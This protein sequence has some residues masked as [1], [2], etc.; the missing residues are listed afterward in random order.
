M[1]SHVVV[2]GPGARRATVKVS[3]GTY[4]SDVL[5]QACK[6]L[7]LPSDKYVAKH[8]AKQVDLSVPFRTSGLSPGAKLDL[9]LKSNTPS[10]I[11]VA[12]QLPQPE[13]KDIP[14]G[15]L[16]RKFPSDLTLWQLLRQFESGDA[17]AGRNINITARGVAQMSN[18]TA[19]AGSGQLYYE[20]PVL[21]I[22]GRELSTLDDFQKT[23]SQ[24]GYNSGSV[25]IRL[26]YKVTD[27]TLYDTLER[28]GQYF[29]DV[30]DTLPKPASATAA[31]NTPVVEAP[32]HVQT[33]DSPMP[34]V[35]PTS[36]EPE[37]TAPATTP[38]PSNEA[39]SVDMPA[40]ASKDPFQPSHVYLAPSSDVPAAAKAPVREVDYTPTIAHAQ[41]HQARLQENS[42]N[43]RL[44]SDK[45]LEEKAAAEEAKFAAVK[46]VS[47]KV[48]FP[49]NTSSE[50]VVGHGETGGF[51]YE[52]VRH[53]MADQ[54]Q[55]FKL[56]I[57]GGRTVIKDDSSASNSLIRA[58]KLTGRTLVN[59]VW[60]DSVSTEVRKKP[61]LKSSV[62]SQGESVKIPEVPEVEE[63]EPEAA[64]IVEPK[65]EKSKGD[66]L[67]KKMPK[68]LKMGKK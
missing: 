18:E 27:Q 4:L 39:D 38:A 43:K 45:E 34:D 15:R 23:L 65:E 62:A 9:V 40:S 6:S 68:W 11:Q 25:L 46:T 19:T 28:I 35:A 47:V 12:L 5:Q 20:T 22:M 54:S 32:T 7:N 8:K 44:L 21:N 42:R 37:P 56:V 26:G 60:D 36:Q 61:F 29:K 31:T 24:L 17:S 57:S 51:I 49:D 30:E 50:W 3:P 67:G 1:S 59:L 33:V 52:A 63:E 66:G 55:P 16:I 14:G 41:L 2:I 10:A 53:V 58:Y 48:R 13:A 64:P